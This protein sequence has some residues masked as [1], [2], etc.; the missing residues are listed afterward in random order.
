MQKSPKTALQAAIGGS[1]RALN[2]FSSLRNATLKLPF[3]LEKILALYC[4]GR[5]E[6]HSF[7]RL[8]IALYLSLMKSSK[9]DYSPTKATLCRAIARSLC[10]RQLDYISLHG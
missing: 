8:I 7:S 3:P 6:L 4:I 2:P 9:E 5:M 1:A 10:V